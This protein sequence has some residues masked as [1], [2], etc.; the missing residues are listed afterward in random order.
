MS[1]SAIYQ[2]IKQKAIKQ[3]AVSA[4][5][6]MADERPAPTDWMPF[7][8]TLFMVLGGL[9]L[10]VALLFFLAYNW[11]SMGVI[12]KF[13]M[14]QAGLFLTV[15]GLWL[16]KTPAFYNRFNIRPKSLN[17]MTVIGS[18]VMVLLIGGLLALFGQVYQTGADPWQLFALWAL[19][20]SALAITSGQS[21][22]WVMWSSIINVALFLLADSRPLMLL[23][24]NHSA[25]FIWL[26]FMVNTALWMLLELLSK[27]SPIKTDKGFY[28]RCLMADDW[29][30]QLQSL[31]LLMCLTIMG[32]MAIFEWQSYALTRGLV[33]LLGLAGLYAYYRYHRP[34]LLFLA[35]WMM[36]LITLLV[37]LVIQLFDNVFNE[38]VL[39]LLAILVIALTAAAVAWLK[40]IQ[41]EW[42]DE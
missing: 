9:A 22:L 27:S 34:D 12:F 36:T 10:A 6:I 16:I 18:V 35:F 37:T 4:A 28:Q 38:S 41:K 13:A 33:V 19:L 21:V 15:L 7:L 40:S 39:L 14:V 1:Q 3:D 31:A 20:I 23:W 30:R 25:D 29:G 5:L 17:L 2:W 42:Q 24:F 32:F 11:Q 26:F 8:K